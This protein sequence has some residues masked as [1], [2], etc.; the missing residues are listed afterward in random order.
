MAVEDVDECAEQITVPGPV[1]LC[2]A[3]RV[4]TYVPAASP[5]IACKRSSL[6]AIKYL[7][8]GK[9]EDNGVVVCQVGIGKGGGIFCKIDGK[10]M[11]ICQPLKGYLPVFNGGMAVSSRLRKNEDSLLASIVCSGN[12]TASAALLSP[13]NRMCC[14]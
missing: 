5:N 11:F 2:I 7:T 13:T 6:V 9:Q 8:G 3:G 12:V 1:V 4:N 14:C 10:V